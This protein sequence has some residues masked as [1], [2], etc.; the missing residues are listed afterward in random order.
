MWLKE[1]DIVRLESFDRA[2]K[3]YRKYLNS[4]NK[5]KIGIAGLRE[6]VFGIPKSDYDVLYKKNPHVISRIC[7]SKE[8]KIEAS[9]YVFLNFFIKDFD[10]K[11][12]LDDNLFK[13]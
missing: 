8:F 10:N 13:I 6:F 11:I 9:C 7:S 3:K 4:S 1:G 2:C 5:D 12:N